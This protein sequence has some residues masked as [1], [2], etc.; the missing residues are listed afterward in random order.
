MKTCSEIISSKVPGHELLHNDEEEAQYRLD[1][2]H[3]HMF[4]DMFLELEKQ[5]EEL[6]IANFGLDLT[7][8]DDVFLKIGELDEEE[9][10]RDTPELGDI[11]K[12]PQKQKNGFVASNEQLIQKQESG[13]RLLMVQLYGLLAKRMIYTWRRKIL[14]ISMMLIPITMAVFIVLSLNPWSGNV[15]ERPARLLDLESYK[16]TG[17]HQMKII[18]IL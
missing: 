13:A 18:T 7:T 9:G 6:G 2:D 8:M 17:F 3:S 14:Y 5:K 11:V 1:N 16:V 12:V 10:D 15:R 4:P